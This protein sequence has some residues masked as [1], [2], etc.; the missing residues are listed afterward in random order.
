MPLIAAARINLRLREM[1]RSGHYRTAD[2]R[3]DGCDGSGSGTCQHCAGTDDGDGGSAAI[4]MMITYAQSGGGHI[5]AFYDQAAEEACRSAGDRPREPAVCSSIL[6][7]KIAS[8]RRLSD[9]VVHTK[10]CLGAG[11]DAQEMAH[12]RPRWSLCRASLTNQSQPA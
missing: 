6:R 11:H 1:A 8:K 7:F 9:G 3:H 12:L 5:I 2:A 4:P 10:D